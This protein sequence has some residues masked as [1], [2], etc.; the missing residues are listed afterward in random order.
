MN[1]RAFLVIFLMPA[2]VLAQT[3]SPDPPPIEAIP[4][5]ED[6]IVPLRKGQPAPFT[7][8]LF[9]P[10]TALRWGNWLQ[11]YKYRLEWDVAAVRKSY[12]VEL[13]YKDE[14]L[15]NER[16]RAA[17]VEKDLTDR[18][19]RAE[20]A[21]LKAEEEARNPP[22]YNTRTFGVVVGVLATAAVFGI[23]VAAVNAT[24]PATL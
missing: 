10:N 13:T 21:R 4:P 18:L 20:K 2:V 9:D 24:R 12:E 6:V 16:E 14:I 22:W 15:T 5:G 23:A 11:Q 3:P 1:W 7:G 17:K 8:Q 19:A